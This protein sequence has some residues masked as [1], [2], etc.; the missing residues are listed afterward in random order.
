MRRNRRRQQIARALSVLIGLVMLAAG[1][2]KLWL[3]RPQDL[4]AIILQYQIIPPSMALKAALLLPLL[5]IYLGLLLVFGLWL[6]PLLWGTAGVFAAFALA[7][8]S[9]KARGLTLSTC[10]CFPSGYAGALKCLL[11]G[12]EGQTRCLSSGLE[13]GLNWTDIVRTLVLLGLSL[14]AAV[15][16]RVA[17]EETPGPE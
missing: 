10:G 6:R 7:M 5:E 1:V 17:P 13:G 14:Y 12:Q 16:M 11:F 15:K 9:V 8:L 2:G 4:V 3:E